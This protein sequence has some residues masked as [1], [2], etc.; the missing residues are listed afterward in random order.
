MLLTHALALSANQFFY[1]RKSPYEYV[2]SVR[3]EVA[4]LILVVEAENRRSPTWV[5]TKRSIPGT[6]HTTRGTIGGWPIR[7]R[8]RK[9]FPDCIMQCIYKWLKRRRYT[10]V[11]LFLAFSL[12]A[13]T[14]YN[15]Y[16]STTYVA[17]FKN[18]I[19]T[20]LRLRLWETKNIYMWSLLY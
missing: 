14:L 19:I 10:S 13:T 7:G 18:L 3:I 16:S 1:A 9:P 15:A 2:H 8:A 12:S 5:N 4:K 6:F 20:N 11:Y 17:H